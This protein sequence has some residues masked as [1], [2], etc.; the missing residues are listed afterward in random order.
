M[1]F[2]NKNT[3]STDNCSIILLRFVQIP[4]RA[5]E[6]LPCPAYEQYPWVWESTCWAHCRILHAVQAALPSL[7]DHPVTSQVMVYVDFEH[8]TSTAACRAVFPAP[9]VVI[10]GSAPATSRHCTS[11]SLPC[12]ADPTKRSARSP[13]VM[14]RWAPHMA[15]V[16][17]YLCFVF[18]IILYQPYPDN[19]KLTSLDSSK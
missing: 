14:P 9:A 12:P 11:S 15:R 2:T 4:G 1:Y 19:L 18:Y 5:S 17:G 8:L 13:G 7:H 16:W 3:T 10:L 6:Y